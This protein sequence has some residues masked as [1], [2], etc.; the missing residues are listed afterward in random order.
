MILNNTISQCDC[1]YTC[2]MLT[3]TQMSLGP[4]KVRLQLLFQIS[5]QDPHSETKPKWRQVNGKQ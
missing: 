5:Y 3:V 2:A 1:S 4:V